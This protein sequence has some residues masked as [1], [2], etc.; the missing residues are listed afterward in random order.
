MV[1][2]PRAFYPQ[3]DELRV[4]K[5]VGVNPEF[6]SNDRAPFAQLVSVGVGAYASA[7]NGSPTSASSTLK[8][9]LTALIAE[10]FTSSSLSNAGSTASLQVL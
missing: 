5:G 9:L 8:S 6:A 3:V 4:G 1:Q 10:S 2:E 7:P